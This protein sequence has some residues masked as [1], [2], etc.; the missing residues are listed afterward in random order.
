V[1]RPTV[2]A[3]AEALYSDLQATQPLDE[4]LGWPF[5]ILVAGFTEGLATIYD[6]VRDS[7]DG[8]GWTMLV[9]PDR[10]PASLLFWLA[11]TM[12][13]T[14]PD[15]DEDA[16][17][18]EI[19]DLPPQR[20]CTEAVARDA[21]GMT[22]TGS[23]VF[24]FTVQGGGLYVD[25]LEVYEAQCPDPAATFAAADAQMPAWRKLEMTVR[26]GWTIAAM[27]TAYD[28]KTIADLEADFADLADLEHN[29]PEA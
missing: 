27:E 18:A 15:A 11:Q 28:G 26:P 14:L 24:H 12:G 19:R 1:S 5:L 4:Q 22:L 8:P 13:V 6:L 29:L 23:K 9:D 10:A 17:R 21:A 2:P 25:T 16:Q 20:R 7:D 3:A